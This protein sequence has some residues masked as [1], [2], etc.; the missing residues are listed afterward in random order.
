MILINCI[1]I[2]VFWTLFGI[3]MVCCED[4]E[5]DDDG[6]WPHSLACKAHLLLPM[7][8]YG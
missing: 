8:A 3:D 7:E 2:L 4:D 1:I 5:Y 6:D